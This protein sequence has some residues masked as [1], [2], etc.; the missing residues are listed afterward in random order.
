MNE[1]EKLQNIEYLVNLKWEKRNN[2][3]IIFFDYHI[4][5]YG[6]ALYNDYRLI[7]FNNVGEEIYRFNKSLSGIVYQK[8]RYDKIQEQQKL[9]DTHML[10]YIQEMERKKE[11]ENVD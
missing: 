6:L 9:L 11:G 2:G 3:E 5:G 1:L 10:E 7:L 8:L 4:N